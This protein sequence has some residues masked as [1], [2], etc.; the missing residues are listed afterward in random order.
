M[1]S[2]RCARASTRG[3]RRSAAGTRD[4]PSTGTTWSSAGSP[5]TTSVGAVT[6]AQS[7]RESCAVDQPRPRGHARRRQR[8]ASERAELRAR[9]KRSRVAPRRERRARSPA[10]AATATRRGTADRTATAARSRTACRGVRLPA[11]AAAST[12]RTSARHA[13][14]MRAPRSAAR[15][16][17]RTTRRRSTARSMP[18]VVEHAV[19]LLDVAVEARARDRTACRGRLVA[20]RERD[21]AEVPRQRVDGR[22]HLLPAALDAGNRRRAAGPVPRSI[23]VHR[24]AVTSVPQRLPGLQRVLDPL[25]RLALAAQ[26]R[27][28]SRSRSS[29]YCFADRRRVRQRAAGQDRARASGRSAR[30]DR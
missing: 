10:A 11:R 3:R 23:D 28:A 6:R 21:D 14:G 19:D 20:Q 4:V 17:R 27:N 16:G 8:R 9:A 13:L 29:S 1:P 25:E 12:T 22:P 15:S 24:S 30:R 2:G 26:L 18:R 7:A 5:V